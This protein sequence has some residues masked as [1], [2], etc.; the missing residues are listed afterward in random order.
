MSEFRDALMRRKLA[1]MERKA[2]KECPR[3]EPSPKKEKKDELSV[4]EREREKL[5]ARKREVK[6]SIRVAK[7]R[8]SDL[9]SKRH[10]LVKELKKVLSE[11]ERAKKR[12]LESEDGELPQA[13][14]SNP[15]ASNRLPP[16]YSAPPSMHSSNLASP[17]QRT[18]TDN[19][20]PLPRP[21]ARAP[22][23]GGYYS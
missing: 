9:E 14:F 8:L 20:A 4:L 6:T 18:G 10:D 11:E 2:E 1:E 16:S 15:D 7:K 21:E 13:F 12:A 22:H 17:D 5:V 23:E 3:K 19:P